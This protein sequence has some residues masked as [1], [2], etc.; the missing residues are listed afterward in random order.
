RQAESTSWGARL[1]R[2]D[3]RFVESFARLREPRALTD[4]E[5]IRCLRDLEEV[6]TLSVI[7][8]RTRRRDIG[9]FTIREPKTVTV[10]FT[11]AQKEFYDAII[12]FRR[13]VLRLNYNPAIVGLITDTLQR[14]AASCLP[15]LAPAIDSFLHTGRFR[16]RNISDDIEDEADEIELD[17]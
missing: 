6:H 17:P 9:R 13:E 3:P 10:E 12:E 5:R 7:M 11:K 2:Q 1:L 15:A 8:N 16:L 4:E 14:Q